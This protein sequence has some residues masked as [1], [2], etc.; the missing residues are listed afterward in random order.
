MKN[1]STAGTS[2][3]GA[4]MVHQNDLNSCTTIWQIQNLIRS[5]IEKDKKLCPSA[6]EYG[7]QV[8]AKL[9]TIRTYQSALQYIYNII[10]AG[11]NEGCF[12]TDEAASRKRGA[13]WK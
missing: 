7:K 5:I 9:S 11:D 10:L 12:W 8:I 4:I 1:L 3:S 2:F 6:I 13:K